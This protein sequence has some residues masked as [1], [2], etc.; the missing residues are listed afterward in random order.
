M[1]HQNEVFQ[2]DLNKQERPGAVFFI[3]LDRKSVV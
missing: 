2:Q 1:D 3:Q